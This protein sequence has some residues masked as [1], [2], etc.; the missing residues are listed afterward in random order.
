[1]GKRINQEGTYGKQTINGIDY[2]FYVFP[3]DNNGKRKK[4][5]ARTQAE[6][7]GKIDEY[8]KIKSCNST[9]DSN[10]IFKD[11]CSDYLKNGCFASSHTTDTY[12]TWLVII[13]NWKKYNIADMLAKDITP[14][15]ITQFLF[16]I[17]QNYARGTIARINAFIVSSLKYG[18]NKE[19]IN[20]SFHFDN[21]KIP[22]ERDVKV[23]VKKKEIL[24]ASDL[25]TIANECLRKKNLED[26]QYD[27]NGVVLYTILFTGCR[28]TELIS[29][30]WK[31]VANDYSYIDIKEVSNFVYTNEDREKGEKH[32]EVTPPKTKNSERRIPIPEQA[33]KI[34]A[35]RFAK[36]CERHKTNSKRDFEDEF[37][38][39]NKNDD[40]ISQKSVWK[41]CK[42]VVKNCGLLSTNISPHTL[43]HAYGSFLISKGVD[44]KIVSK[45]LGHSSVAFTYDVYINVL[46]SS[47]IKAIDLLNE[48]VK[49]KSIDSILDE[50][51][52][53]P[54][55]YRNVNEKVDFLWSSDK[56]KKEQEE[57]LSVY[58][59]DLSKLKKEITKSE[60]ST[61]H[62]KKETED[63][64]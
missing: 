43:R 29:L 11:L 15:D 7:K 20:S 47:E 37:V 9:I 41:T 27:I 60:I 12:R 8:K 10:I 57:R 30:K 54:D 50:E 26:Y 51:Q 25:Y 18:I 28:V 33:Q 45:L 19:I 17:S 64:V 1:M 63:E 58:A 61:S 4:I 2:F 32:L 52:S 56:G 38:F 59:K 31:Y 36:A 39:L 40:I 13:S 49:E 21:I 6:L 23:K 46:R 55:K 5:Y 35:E 16:S 62:L 48:I 14:K 44:I 24:E 3:V 34:F 42:T 53:I 22:S